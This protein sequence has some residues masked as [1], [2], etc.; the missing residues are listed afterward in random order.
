MLRNKLKIIV[1]A[2][3]M[4]GFLL[5]GCSGGSGGSDAQGSSGSEESGSSSGS[6]SKEE[7]EVQAMIDKGLGVGPVKELKMKDEINQEWVKEG[8]KLFE[9]KC[10]ACHKPLEDHLAPAPVGVL[11]RRKPEWIMNM[12]LNPME[13]VQQDP[14]AQKLQ[15]EYNNVMSQQITDRKKARKILE[16][17]RTLEKK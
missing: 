15:S 14:T 13:M 8:E 7:K 12:I 5:V 17:F 6:A 11:D 1:L 3:G 10:T 16:Y 4:L 2:F 9:Q